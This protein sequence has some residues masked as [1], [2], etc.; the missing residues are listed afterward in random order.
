MREAP[1][2]CVMTTAG[3]A[4]L[5]PSIAHALMG[6]PACV[7]PRGTGTVVKFAGVSSSAGSPGMLRATA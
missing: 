6:L 2:P 7:F 5:S 1:Q 4:G 3:P